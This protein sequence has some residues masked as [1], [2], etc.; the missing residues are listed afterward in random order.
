VNVPYDSALVLCAD[1]EAHRGAMTVSASYLIQDDTRATRD[2]VDWVPEFS[3]RARLRR[4][5]GASLA[6]PQRAG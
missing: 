1:P 5:R 2:Q 3:R 6:W 4:L